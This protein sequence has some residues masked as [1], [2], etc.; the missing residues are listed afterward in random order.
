M[1]QLQQVELRRGILCLLQQANL[2]VFPGQKVGIIGANGCGKST[3]FALLQGKL[4]ADAG[5][6]S[7]PNSWTIATVAQET[8]AVDASAMDYVLQ[9]DEKLYPLLQQVKLAHEDTDLILVHQQIE[10]LDGY[11]AEAKAGTL[12]DG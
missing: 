7:I 10:A 1:I 2:T 4:Q 5:T 11:S 12:L 3:L 8:P 6:V 9:G